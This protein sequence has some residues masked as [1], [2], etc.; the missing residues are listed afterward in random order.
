MEPVFMLDRRQEML[1]FA[2][3]FNPG[4]AVR[5]ETNRRKKPECI[6]NGPASRLKHRA[7]KFFIV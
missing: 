3:L 2:A 4:F 7:A 6:A 5:Y 1:T